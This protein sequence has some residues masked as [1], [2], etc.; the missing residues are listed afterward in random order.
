MFS[1]LKSLSPHTQGILAMFLAAVCYIAINSF[2]RPL[3]QAFEPVTST[4]LRFLVA[5]F[6]ALMLFHR[7]LNIHKIW[8]APV[9]D[10]VLLLLIGTVGGIFAMWAA[11]VALLKTTLLNVALFDALNPILAYLYSLILIKQRFRWQI[12]ALAGITVYGTMVVVSK[13][14]F[15]SLQQFGLGE[16]LACVAVALFSLGFTLRKLLT[17]HLNSFEIALVLM[18]ITIVIMPIITWLMG[19]HLDLARITWPIIATLLVSGFVTALAMLLSTFG[20]KHLEAT[21]GS[22]ILLSK[23]IFSLFAGLLFFQE[24]PQPISIF[25]AVIVLMGTYLAIRFTNA[26]KKAAP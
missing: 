6:F 10:K 3:N 4:F 25:G 11:T 21:L 17:H 19:E 26:T 16:L 14:F 8:T 15:P 12:V 13:S 24:V 1:H 5:T 23:V 7:Q 18:S 22:Q 20:F 2:V 9:K